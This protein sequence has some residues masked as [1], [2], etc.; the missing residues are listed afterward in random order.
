MTI[1][2]TA[3]VTILG[4]VAIFVLGQLAA[5]FFIEPIHEQYKIIGDIAYHL[6]YYANIYSNPGIDMVEIRNE[7]STTFRQSACKLRATTHTIFW[8]KLWQLLRLIPKQR[9]VYEAS[10]L[11][12]G[13]SNSMFRESMGNMIV[14]R[15]RPSE[16]GK[17]LGIRSE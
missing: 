15:D 8:Y 17:L 7:A 13:L 12:I 16:V 1:F 3:S 9:D 4:G 14:D 2:L 5:K 10:R 11:L 6:V